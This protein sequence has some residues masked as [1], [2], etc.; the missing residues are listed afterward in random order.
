MWHAYSAILFI[1]PQ[2]Y[3]S[4]NDTPLLIRLARS[5]DDCVYYSLVQSNVYGGLDVFQ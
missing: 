1:N 2:Q 4:S 5:V 3:C